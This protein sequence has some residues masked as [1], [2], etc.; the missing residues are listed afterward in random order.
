MIHSLPILSA[1]LSPF[2]TCIKGNR[3]LTKQDIRLQFLRRGVTTRPAP[4]PK[5]LMCRLHLFHHLTVE[6]TKGYECDNGLEG[7]EREKRCALNTINPLHT[8]WAEQAGY[9]SFS[10]EEVNTCNI[11]KKNFK[12]EGKEL[13]SLST[14]YSTE[15][16]LLPFQFF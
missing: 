8:F 7:R 1:T 11:P 5:H 2:Y 16:I 12:E 10:C 15:A 9:T 6:K 3:R 4:T 14:K 13:S